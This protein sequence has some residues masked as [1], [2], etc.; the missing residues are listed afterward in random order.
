MRVLS[1]K[2]IAVDVN[3]LVPVGSVESEEEGWDAGIGLMMIGIK[4][5]GGRG[6]MAVGPAA[7]GDLSD[8]LTVE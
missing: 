8:M 5:D 4:N 1:Y 7:A 2:T 3:G 6:G